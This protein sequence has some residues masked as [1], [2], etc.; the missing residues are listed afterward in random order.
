[1]RHLTVIILS[2]KESE[3]GRQTLAVLRI[4]EIVA[5]SIECP[6]LVGVVT[7]GVV[8]LLVALRQA[9]HWHRGHHAGHVD[10]GQAVGELVDVDTVDAVLGVHLPLESGLTSSERTISC[11]TMDSSVKTLTHSC[12]ESRKTLLVYSS[13]SDVLDSSSASLLGR[14]KAKA[15]PMADWGL[16]PMSVEFSYENDT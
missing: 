11:N 1:M 13:S 14:L 3:Q 10:V 15:V 7:R 6:V 8:L 16:A 5:P 2:R 4:V 12:S 9:L